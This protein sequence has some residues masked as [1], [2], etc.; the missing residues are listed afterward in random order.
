ML[1]NNIERTDLKFSIVSKTITG[2]VFFSFVVGLAFVQGWYKGFGL[3][4][5]NQIEHEFISFVGFLTSFLLFPQI[6]IALL[7]SKRSF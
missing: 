2:I 6:L 1:N 5:S 3:L 4:S 7:E